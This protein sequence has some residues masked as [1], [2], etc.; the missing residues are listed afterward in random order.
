MSKRNKI[1]KII[2]FLIVGDIFLNSGWGLVGPIFAIYL[3]QDIQGGSAQVAG[4]ATA[5]FWITK[6]I[7]QIPLAR[8]LDRNHGEKDDFLFMI[9][10]LFI[11][12]LVPFGY[13]ASSL[14]WHIYILQV[15]YAIGMAM[16]VPAWYAIFTRHIDKGNEAYEWSVYSTVLGFAFGISGALGGLIVGFVGFKVIYFIV[17]IFTITPSILLLFIKNDL[18]YPRPRKRKLQKPI[19]PWVPF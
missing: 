19:P 5:I 11:A 8:Y 15:I 4:F 9:G 12:G 7:I 2:K 1:N 17:G 6:S 14:P 3:L 16:A 18:I 13:L 10:G